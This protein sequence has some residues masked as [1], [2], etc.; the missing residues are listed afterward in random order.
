MHREPGSVRSCAAREQHACQR[1]QRRRSGQRVRPSQALACRQAR[2]RLCLRLI[3]P[4]RVTG[5]TICKR[6]QCSGPR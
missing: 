2:A 3:W 4:V 5:V 6:M 1:C